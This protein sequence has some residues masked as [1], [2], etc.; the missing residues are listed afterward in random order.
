MDIP[1]ETDIA[2]RIPLASFELY[3]QFGC[4]MGLELAI[5][6]AFG[7]NNVFWSYVIAATGTIFVLTDLYNSQ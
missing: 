1:E 7:N 3:E 4:I 6:A 2:S 5:K